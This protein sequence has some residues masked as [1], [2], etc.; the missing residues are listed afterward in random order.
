MKSNSILPLT[1]LV[2]C[3]LSVAQSR[4]EQPAGSAPN[5][6][7]IAVDDLRPELGIYGTKT[8]TPNVDQ[9]AKSGVRF[10][11]AY[12]QQSVC[13]ASRLS[14]MTGLY[15]TRT[16]EHSFHITGW[17]KRHPDVVTLNQ[18]FVANGYNTIGFGKIYHLTKGVEVDVDNWTKWIDLG[19]DD[20]YA[21]P[22]NKAS[23]EAY[24]KAIA[25]GEKKAIRGPL[26]ENADVPNEAYVDGR[27]ATEAAKVLTGLGELEKSENVE[28]KPF[29]LA[30]GFTKPH[31]PFVAPRKYWDLYQRDDFKMPSNT[32]IPLGYLEAAAKLSA[33]EMDKYKGYGNGPAG[34]SDELKKELLHG[35]AASTSYTDA[36][37]GVVLKALRDNGLEDNTIVVFWG[38]HGWKLGDHSSWCKQTNF[39]CDTRVPLIVRVPGQLADHA[40]DGLVELIDLYPTLCELAKIKTPPHCQGKSF[41]SLLSN[42]NAQHRD[43]AYSVY[44]TV[45]KQTGHSIRFGDYRYTQ[46]RKNGDGTQAIDGVLTNLKND[47]GE[48]TNVAQDQA[49]AEI[50]KQGT[51]LLDQRIREA[52]AEKVRN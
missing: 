29:F 34:F 48:V 40:T 22:E 42:K 30:I 24:N 35:Y 52:V 4:A 16:R 32:A 14:L 44:P 25:A 1:L 45:E 37:I 9:F 28:A 12:C 47:P 2:L 17:R 20:L 6:L 13:G 26:T 5:I 49:H 15:P 51:A 8:K 27:R 10:D 31:L 11:R 39:E 18:H 7:F 38:D 33:T 19:P 41:A 43:S 50:L 3:L 21:L 46:W 23:M 36:N